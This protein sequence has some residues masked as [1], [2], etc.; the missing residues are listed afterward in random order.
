MPKPEPLGNRIM[1]RKLRD[2]EL[3]DKIGSLWIPDPAKDHQ[4]FMRWKI[5]EV[6]DD[7]NDSFIIWE[8]DMQGELVRRWTAEGKEVIVRARAGSSFEWDGEEYMMV[9][10]SDIISFIEEET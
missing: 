3:T 6:G 2:D 1:L 9:S 10:E 8:I 4:I 5:A 7:C